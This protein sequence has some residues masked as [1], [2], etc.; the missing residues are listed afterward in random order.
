MIEIR[1]EFS[2]YLSS[3]RE[4]LLR[5]PLTL[6]NLLKARSLMDSSYEEFTKVLARAMH[7]Y[8]VLICAGEA[9]HG[10]E[11][12]SSHYHT[13]FWGGR[14]SEVFDEAKRFNPLETLKETKWVFSGVGWEDGYGGEAWETIAHLGLRYYEFES[15]PDRDTVFIDMC[16]DLRHNNGFAFDKDIIFCPSGYLQ[17]LLDTKKRKHGIG[18]SDLK[19]FVYKA[20][21]VLPRKFY[22]GLSIL[23]N[24]K[25]KLLDWLDTRGWSLIRV[26]DYHLEELKPL[27]VKWRNESLPGDRVEREVHVEEE[28]EDWI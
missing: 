16:F 20:D 19:E 15:L 8:I 24:L 28:D 21:L 26:S 23:K 27:L 22:S 9:R 3:H 14:R 4:S 5:R 17:A 25:V 2:S 1:E 18:V 10:D 13:A 6:K 12:G 11:R 7:D